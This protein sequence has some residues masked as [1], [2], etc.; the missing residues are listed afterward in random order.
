MVLLG[1][2]APLALHHKATVAC[3]GKDSSTPEWDIPMQP[4]PSEVFHFPVVLTGWEGSP[5]L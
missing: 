2:V 4:L 3:A 5:L 1:P